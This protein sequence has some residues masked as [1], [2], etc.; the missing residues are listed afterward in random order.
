[1]EV[2][3]LKE[4]VRRVMEKARRRSASIGFV[5]TMGYF[6]EG[7]L[8]LMRIARSRCDFTVVSIFVNPIQFAPGEDLAGYPRDLERD[9]SLAEKEGV[10]LVFT[11]A[12]EE[13]HAPDRSTFVEETE[14]SKG[15]CGKSRPGHFRG[16]TT[17]VAKLFNIVGPCLAV[18]GR[19]DLQQLAVVRRMVRDLDFPV[20]I[21]AAPIV[22]EADGL[23]MS[24]RNVYLSPEERRRAAGLYRGLEKGARYLALSASSDDLTPIIRNLSREIEEETGGSLEYLTPVDR[25]MIEVEK[26]GDCRFL[27][28]ALRLPSAR[29]IDNVEVPAGEPYA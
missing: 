14:I 18:F 1:M 17:V 4:E 29:L 19:K 12:V 13:M 11:P 9:L 3:K 21:L 5:P 26:A 23:A 25:E 22:R 6:H 28:A 24:S 27:A 15:L 20:E 10:D 16:V 8:S 7:H 2:V